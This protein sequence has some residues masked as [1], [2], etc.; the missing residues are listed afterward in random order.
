MDPFFRVPLWLTTECCGGHTLWAF[1]RRHLDLLHNYV[2]AKVRERAGG[3]ERGGMTLVAR[4][5]RWVKQASNRD[6]LLAAIAELR[7]S[8]D[9]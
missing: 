5:P 1:N 7:A 3:Y 9:A 6:E 8:I 2:A 4:L